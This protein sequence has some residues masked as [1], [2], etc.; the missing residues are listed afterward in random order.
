MHEL[1]LELH[2]PV[3]ELCERMSA[4]ELAVAWPLFFDWRRRDAERQR[5]REKARPG[6]RR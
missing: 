6:K 1:A 5:E 3:G 4:H 2:M